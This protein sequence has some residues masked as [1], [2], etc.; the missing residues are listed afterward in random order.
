MIIIAENKHNHYLLK[1]FYKEISKVDINESLRKDQA[2]EHTA[3]DISALDFNDAIIDNPIITDNLGTEVDKEDL[4]KASQLKPKMKNLLPLL[5]LKKGLKISALSAAL[6]FSG[7]TPDEEF[8]AL[9]QIAN[10]NNIEVQ[11]VIKV[12][13]NKPK[14]TAYSATSNVSKENQKT[15]MKNVSLSEKS[16]LLARS[17][18]RIKNFEGFKPYPYKDRDGVSIGYGTFFID[19]I[20]PDNLPENWIDNLYKKCNISDSEKSQYEQE[21]QKELLKNFSETIK[22][23]KIKIDKVIL[24]VNNKIKLKNA[25]LKKWKKIKDTKKRKRY[26][27]TVEAEIERLGERKD[28]LENQK[29]DLD[30]E[31]ETAKSRGFISAE[32]AEECLNRY[33]NQSIDYHN[34]NSDVFNKYF[35][36]MDKD[37]QDVIIDMSYNVGMYFLEEEFPNFQGF[38]KEYINSIANNNDQLGIQSLKNMFEEIKNRSPEYHAQQSSN[39]RAEKNTNLLKSAHERAKNNLKENLYSLKS[40]YNILYS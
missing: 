34:T 13:N 7:D 22:A 23:K 35:F 17:K 32:L 4:I 37:V 40:V 8:K 15:K 29:N 18:T 31:K 3:L 9:R 19:N 10:D 20:E 33:I 36:Q 1:N 28:S 2:G 39:K 12:T 25:E 21:N 11:Q 6:F 5:N 38:V 26:T 24:R 30:L 14:E 27:D 16:K